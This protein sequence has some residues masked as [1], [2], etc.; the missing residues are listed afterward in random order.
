MH[1]IDN[2]GLFPQES[3]EGIHVRDY[4]LSNYAR[5]FENFPYQAVKNVVFRKHRTSFRKLI[6]V[7]L[8]DIYIWYFTL[9]DICLMQTFTSCIHFPYTFCI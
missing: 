9:G 4:P 5:Y 1:I 8:L 2:G 6:G 3:L 7:Y